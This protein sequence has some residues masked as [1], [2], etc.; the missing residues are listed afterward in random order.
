[1]FEL[2]LLEINSD[3]PQIQH[4]C[5]NSIT[6]MESKEICLT[7]RNGQANEKFTFIN[8]IATSLFLLHLSFAC[9]PTFHWK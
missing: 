6:S 7:E 2:A 3:T 5:P 9:N 4:C 1:M 8:A